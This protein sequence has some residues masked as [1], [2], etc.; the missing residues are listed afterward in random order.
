MNTTKKFILI[1]LFTSII[2]AIIWLILR[3]VKKSNSDMTI[4]KGAKNNPG[5]LRYTNEKWQG[6]IYPE[7]GQKFVFESFDTLEHGIRA[8]LINARTQI[9]RGYNTIDKLIDRL[10]PASENPESARKAMKQEIKQVLGTNTIAVSDL[11]KIAP[12]IFKH[13]GNPDY[14]AHGQGIQIYGIQQKYNIV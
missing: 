13:E 12:I 2:I 1:A 4:V 10:T 8:W 7:P 3:K 9:K 11:W 14:L 5:H 6:K